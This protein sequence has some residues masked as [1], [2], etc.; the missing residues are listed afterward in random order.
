MI[1]YNEAGYSGIRLLAAGKNTI[2][3]KKKSIVYGSAVIGQKGQI[4]I[5]VKLRKDLNL[6]SGDTILFIGSDYDD[7]FNVV[8]GDSLLKL[9]KKMQEKERDKST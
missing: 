1:M 9:H 5:P 6:K 7:T 4:V 3:D 2:M 8:K